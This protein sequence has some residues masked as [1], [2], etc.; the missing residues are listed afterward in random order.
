M[1]LEQVLLQTDNDGLI[2]LAVEGRLGDFAQ[3]ILLYQQHLT[4]AHP[5]LLRSS[6]ERKTA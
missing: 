4:G 6:F 2:V 5:N 3:L 1:V